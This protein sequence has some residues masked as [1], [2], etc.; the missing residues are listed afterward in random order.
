MG[1]ITPELAINT[2][3]IAVQT[4]WAEFPASVPWIPGGQCFLLTVGGSAAV[5]ICSRRR[6]TI[7][8][9]HFK[10]PAHMKTV[11]QSVMPGE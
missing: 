2:V 8:R 9:H 10:Q 7:L 6:G 4:T 11:N 3:H 5:P 1:R